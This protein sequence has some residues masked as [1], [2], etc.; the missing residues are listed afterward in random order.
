MEGGSKLVGIDES[1]ESM[2]V[3]AKGTRGVS[4]PKGFEI[5]KRTRGL[6]SVDNGC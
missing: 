5:L 1:D 3:K 2:K 4:G 6:I